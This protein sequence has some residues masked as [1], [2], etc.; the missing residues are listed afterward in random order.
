MTVAGLVLAAGAGRRFGGPK[1]L[2]EVD[3][4]PLVDRAVRVAR[5]GGCDPV[6]VVLGAAAADVV[7]RARLDGAVVLVNDGWPDGMGS[8]LRCGLAAAADLR[9]EGVVVML[10]DQPL[11]TGAV[12]RRLVDRWRAGSSPAVVASYD[13]EPRNPVL[14]AAATWPAVAAAAVGDVGAREWLRAHPDEVERVACDDLG[15]P[16]DVDT[17]ADLDRLLKDDV[18]GT[19]SSEG[20]RMKLEHEF[21]VP[22]PVD[23][24]WKVLLDVERVA[25]CMPGAT[26]LT[27]DGD[28]FTGSVKVKVGP[29]QVTYN[30]QAKFASLD[31]AAHRAVIEASGKETRGSGTAAATVTAVLLDA[32]GSTTNVRVETDLDVTGK[33]AQFGRGV[34]AEVAAKL[35][36]QFSSCLAEELASPAAAATGTA[37]VTD[38]GTA[39]LTTQPEAP[40]PPEA[41]VPTA[42]TAATEAPV[43]AAPAKAA[44]AKKTAAK[45]TAAKKT[46]AK[47]TA[48]KT[49]TAKT[50]PA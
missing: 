41:P 33:P 39:V 44:P 48:A 27:V 49:A 24:A 43:K 28:T 11:V 8:S 26:L 29:I 36:G 14:L 16:A 32:G 17:P 25:P 10:V 12:V 1:A 4:E 19:T 45:K 9:C 38:T 15:R 31:E 5:E 7:A 18:S 50:T 20:Q 46:A 42:P 22:A 13:G 21:T 2:V 40:A 34:M 23:E 30:G 3:G 6:L 35:I 47:K 37:E